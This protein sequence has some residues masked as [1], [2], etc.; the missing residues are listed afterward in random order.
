MV[1]A[2]DLLPGHVLTPADLT[3]ESWP[4]DLGP[5]NA[6]SDPVL[7]VGRTLGAGMSRGEVL[8]AARVRGPGLLTGAGDGLVAA[9]IRL[10][11]PAMAAVAAAGDHVDVISSAGQVV[12]A[13]V[14]VLAVDTRSDG[15]SGWS[16][17]AA[18][19]PSGGL[20]AAVGAAEAVRLATA[21]PSGLSAPT[22]NVVLKAAR[23]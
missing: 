6:F 2:Q 4:R 19:G 12:A 3:V 5:D 8:T 22:F 11:D 13:D 15:S 17:A 14:V 21:D 23:H 7:L 9:H 16:G 20:L 1:V 18:S 10:A